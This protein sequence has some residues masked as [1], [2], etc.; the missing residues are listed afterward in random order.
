MP[1]ESFRMLFRGQNHPGSPA[2]CRNMPCIVMITVL[3]PSIL[4]FYFNSNYVKD[5]SLIYLVSNES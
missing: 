5:I 3:R 2:G 1:N 4:V